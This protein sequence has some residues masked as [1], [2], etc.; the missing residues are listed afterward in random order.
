LYGF[1]S[2]YSYSSPSTVYIPKSV[3]TIS[4]SAFISCK[5]SNVNFVFE[6]KEVN[7][8]AGFPWG[9]SSN[10]TKKCGQQFEHVIGNDTLK[11]LIENN[12]PENYT[13][14]FPDGC[15]GF[16][17]KFHN[18][19][20]VKTLV[21]GDGYSGLQS[22]FS[23]CDSLETVYLGRPSSSYMSV[24]GVFTSCPKFKNIYCSWTQG[25]YSSFESS[26]SSLSGV[27]VTYNTPYHA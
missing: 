17:Y 9:A 26:L 5:S 22:S 25:E 10:S 21:I 3:K 23:N 4:S 12:F 2:T 8:P 19:K 24:S 1:N 15:S 13:L 7:I 20:N 11:C 6:D 27:T 14:V 16:N 18:L